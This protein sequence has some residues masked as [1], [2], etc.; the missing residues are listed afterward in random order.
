ML[1]HVPGPEVE[2]VNVGGDVRGCGEKVTE[3]LIFLICPGNDFAI[4]KGLAGLSPGTAD[5]GAHREHFAGVDSEVVTGVVASS[6][7]DIAQELN[8]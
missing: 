2:F 1:V 3:L 6:L 5:A 7:E 8:G 4:E